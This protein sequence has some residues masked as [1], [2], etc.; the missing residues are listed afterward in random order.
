MRRTSHLIA[1]LV[2]IGLAST[3]NAG[4]MEIY[5]TIKNTSIACQIAG[6]KERKVMS[7][8]DIS[9]FIDESEVASYVTLKS[10]KGYERTFMV[11]GKSAPFSRLRDIKNKGSMSEIAA[12]KTKLFSELE[13]KLIQLSTELDGKAQAAEFVLWDPSVT[14]EKSKRE[15]RD[16]QT[17]LDG[18]RK[19]RDKVCTS[20]PAYEA[21]SK[22]NARLQQTLSN[23]VYSWQTP[24]T[25]MSTYKIFKDKEGAVDLRQLDSSIEHYKNECKK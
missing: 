3:A 10:A 12:E 16:M 20:T 24:G 23:I 17:E 8:E 18:Y 5:C 2:L 6:D 14:F 7:A 13:K 22:G 15:A 21:L 11:D 19:N 1:S 25:C 9:R 4:P